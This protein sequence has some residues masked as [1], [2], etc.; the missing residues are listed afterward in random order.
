MRRTVLFP[1]V[2]VGVAATLPGAAQATST[3]CS[4]S[5][6]CAEY[7]N[8]SSGV[9][10]HGEANTG[11]GIRGTSVSNTGFY[12]AS[13]SGSYMKPG[14]EGES[15]KNSGSDAAGVFGLADKLSNKTAGYGAMGYGLTYGLYGETENTGADASTAGIGVFGTETQ[16][17]YFDVGVMGYS[18]GNIAM[19]AQAGGA[20]QVVSFYGTTVGLYASATSTGNG[21]TAIVADSNIQAI[22]ANNTSSGES[23]SVAGSSDFVSGFN[24]KTSGSFSISNSG[25]EVLSGTLKTSGGTYAR[26]TGASGTKRIAYGTRSAS[27][28]IED[29]GEASMTS[30]RALVTI[31][32]AFGD[33]VDMRHAY[34][35]FLTPDGDCKGLY[36][37]QKSPSSFVVRELQGGR[38]TLTFEY[39]IVA[40][41][42]DE[43]GERLAVDRPTVLPDATPLHR[44]VRVSAPPT[45]EQRLL[46]R[47]GMRDYEKALADTRN[48]LLDK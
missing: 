9:A 43:N 4:T 20:Q 7:I 44:R 23:V 35:V 28:Q 37:A 16:D 14:V 1:A 25:N 24:S 11:I 3:T 41:P 26:T 19:E 22:N 47:V 2:L 34:H 18:G 29:V 6:V 45:P 42:V 40:K 5:V 17:G 30:G 10:I 15:T 48:R 32:A 13:G 31:D 39:R 36:V 8:T 27:P 12:G 46:Q 21:S 38:S 33:S